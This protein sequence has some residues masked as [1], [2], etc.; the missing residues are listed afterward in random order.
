MDN[1]DEIA[2][3]WFDSFKTAEATEVFSNPKA[4]LK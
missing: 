2:K 4:V 3:A 1:L